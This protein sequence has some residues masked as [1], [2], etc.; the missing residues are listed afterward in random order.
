MKKCRYRMFYIRYRSM[1][2][3]N[4]PT[5]SNVLGCYDI[6]ESTISALKSYIDIVALCFDIVA[7]CFD[8]ECASIWMILADPAHA[9]QRTAI[10]GCSSVTLVLGYDCSEDVFTPRG[11]AA[12]R[13][14]GGTARAQAG[15]GA[16]PRWAAPAMAAR[17]RDQV[18]TSFLAVIPPV[19]RRTLCQ[20]L[21]W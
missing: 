19:T 11:Q 6:E 3:S 15:P 16:P 2:I 8:I 9:G 7:L 1:P 4:K 5:I 17:K 13:E 10:A 20:E 12:P 21:Y 14:G 18:C